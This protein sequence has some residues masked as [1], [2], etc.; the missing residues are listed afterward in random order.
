MDAFWCITLSV[1]LIR[2]WW[3]HQA[4]K[5]LINIR[6]NKKVVTVSFPPSKTPAQLQ[7]ERDAEDLRK[8]GYSD[9]IIA[10]ILPVVTNG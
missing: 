8:Q 7:R 9:E 4:G 3:K 5:P 1:V 6:H 2:M 10:T